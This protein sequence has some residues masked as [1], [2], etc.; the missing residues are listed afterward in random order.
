MSASLREALDNIDRWYGKCVLIYFDTGIM[1]KQMIPIMDD[2]VRL[3]R[4]GI[5]IKFCC[6]SGAEHIE[7]QARECNISVHRIGCMNDIIN[8]CKII[9]AIK[10]FFLCEGDG[11]FDKNGYLVTEMTIEQA[12]IALGNML[13]TG[14]M[15]DKVRLS[16]DL[17]ATCG[18][19]RVH[20]V[21]AKR[22]DAFLTEFLSNKG[23]GTMIYG[24]MYKI[25][26]KAVLKDVDGIV[27]MIRA[28]VDG[29]VVED[30]ITRHV[31]NGN[32]M[33]FSV[34]EHAYGVAIGSVSADKYNIEYLT[35]SGEFKEHEVL[36]F[37]LRHVINIAESFKTHAITM[38]SNYPRLIGIYPW[39]LN[40]GF[41]RNS[42]QQW[43]KTLS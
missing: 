19:H 35:H 3:K 34:D 17:C 27:R 18:V 4:I 8:L 16:V 22:H 9:R 12:E 5:N 38:G 11:I 32:A 42:K 26:R 21:N 37:L 39:F 41:V 1:G 23:A 2:A 28:S 33:V 15:R 10:I 29:S 24:N 43:E 14:A 20:F 6:V 36:N 40:L 25:V 31:H 13:I 7:K 30:V